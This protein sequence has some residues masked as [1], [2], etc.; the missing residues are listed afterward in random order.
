MATAAHAAALPR[1]LVRI[2]LMDS[3]LLREFV[4]PFCF[5]FFAFL[6]FWGVNIFYLAA[7]F[8]INAHAPV[9][10]VLRFVLFRIPQSIPLAFP[11]AALFATL[12]A[13]GRLAADNEINAL[14]TAGI[15]LWRIC[16]SPLL[17]GIAAFA[18][19]YGMNELVAPPSVDISTRSFY[20][21]IYHTAALPVEPQFFRKDPDTG[22]VFYVA[23]VEPDNKTM[24]G[25]QVFKPGRSGYYNEI[26]SAKTAHVE[27]ATL[28]LNDVVDTR[29]NANG[30]FAAQARTSTVSIGL[31]LAETAAAFMSSTNNDAFT[32]N[33]KALSQQ[34]HALES[35]GVGG[36][37]LGSMQINL[38]NK[39][40][41]PFACFVAVLL[42]LPIAIKFGKKGRML[43]IALSIVAFGLYD[44][45]LTAAAAFGR[46]GVMNPYLASWTPNIIF[47]LAGLAMLW[48]NER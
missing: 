3:Y 33:S 28:I 32:M 24:V 8:L 42:A 43:G 14:R 10:L 47:G 27:G 36:T 5:A 25:V 4:G 16:L 9:F 20:Q 22:N 17:F 45:L 19:A 23:Q 12:L 37:A 18:V 21:I 1:P 6:L 11:F 41:L 29:F 48:W 35:Q 34:V 39:S 40:A 44:L 46:N 26:L 2:P 31:P 38:A 30:E 7:D 13:V 15:S